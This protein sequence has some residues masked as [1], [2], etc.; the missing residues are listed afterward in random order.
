M[1][2]S[3]IQI[4]FVNHACVVFEANG[5]RLACDPWLTGSAFLDGWDLL[6]PT[7]E[8]IVDLKLTHLWISHEHPDH[9]SPRDLLAIPEDARSAMTVLYQ[10]TADGKVVQFLR[11]KGFT[12][13]V[14]PPHTAVEIAPE[15]SV[16]C[17]PVG[18]D[19][20]LS[21][22]ANGQSILNLN[23]CITGQDIEIEDPDHLPNEP[24]ETIRTHAGS[25]DVL[26]TQFSIANWVGNPEDRHLHRLQA[27]TK[28]VQVRHQIRRLSPRA[29]VPFASFIY[30]SH[31]ENQYLNQ[32]QNTVMDCATVIEEESTVPVVLYPGESYE[33]GTE[34][35][36]RSS[37]ERWRLV[38]EALPSR[39][40]HRSKPVAVEQL[41][42]EFEA[43][44]SR[45]KRRNDWSAIEAYQAMG[46]L[47]PSL[48]YLWDLDQTVSFDLVHGLQVI[49]DGDLTTDIQMGSAS[50][51][52]LIKHDWGRG[53]LM[54][55]ARFSA[56]YQSIQT[57]LAQTQ[58]A[59][60]NNVGLRFPE[61]ISRDILEES[62]SYVAF[63]CR[64]ASQMSG[65]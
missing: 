57:F 6:V 2:R 33:V 9:F 49:G 34:P 46:G 35:D 44:Q 16:M 64:R 58:I 40:Y 37:L 28:F 4:E 60:G 15:V 25:P 63:F 19:S 55:N 65:H 62:P 5:V 10:D 24:L 51:S 8:K 23:D 13:T 59:Y 52:Y 30:F 43:Y 3:S 45:V 11:A 27:R 42:A 32:E 29:V 1:D 47:T 20:W 53:T 48:V 41:E 56:N 31:E 14:L 36:N 50:L 17:G 38:Y 21:F 61:S 12:V 39:T 26:L 54:V 22:K 18:A 7:A